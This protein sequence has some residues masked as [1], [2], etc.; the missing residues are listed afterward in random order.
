MK[1]PK[2]IRSRA[3]WRAFTLIELLV[4]IAII[5]IL[6]AMLLPA[7]TRA[8]NR[9]LRT[10]CL[11]NMR[12]IGLATVM[13]VQETQKYPGCIFINSGYYIWPV[14]LLTQIGTNRSVFWCPAS[15][16]KNTSSAWAKPA[17]TTLGPNYEIWCGSGS[18]FSYAY[19]DWGSYGAFTM[20]GLG[21]D[22]DNTTW[23]IKES[24]VVKPSEMIAVADSKVDGQWDGNLDPTSSDQWPSSRHDRRT[25]IAFCDGHAEAPLRKDVV[26]PA[27]ESWARRWNNDNHW[28]GATAWSYNAT[29]AN[30]VD[31]M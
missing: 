9:A 7:L 18:Y 31:P 27:K 11:S 20:M 4:V 15:K 3:P 28:P 17:N 13:Y 8:K 24:K 25:V 1:T 30:K 16:P 10:Q 5:A 19:N 26:N 22:V 21:G 2:L 12:Q 29:E 6:A 14:R 23:E